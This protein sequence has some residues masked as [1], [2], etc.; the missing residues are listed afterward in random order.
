MDF[1]SLQLDTVMNIKELI[2]LSTF[3]YLGQYV[4][5][6]KNYNQDS[7]IL[8]ILFNSNND[9][10]HDVNIFYNTIIEL[11]KNDEYT[12]FNY[13]T[14]IKNAEPSIPQF[15]KDLFT[16]KGL[17]PNSTLTSK[18]DICKFLR[19]NK[20]DNDPNLHSSN[21]KKLEDS[22]SSLLKLYYQKEISQVINDI[23]SNTCKDVD[24]EQFLNDF[25]VLKGGYKLTK[26]KGGKPI[27]KSKKNC[28]DLIKDINNFIKKYMKGDE[29]DKFKCLKILI[30]RK[31]Y[32]DLLIKLFG[33]I[34]NKEK[35]IEL[36]ALLD[37]VNEQ[38]YQI[39]KGIN[40]LFITDDPKINL[41]KLG[42]YIYKSINEENYDKHDNYEDKDDSDENDSHEID[43][44]EI[45]SHQVDS[46]EDYSSED[47]E[48][49]LGLQ[50]IK[51]DS[52]ECWINSLLQA[53]KGCKSLLEKFYRI[54]DNCREPL[55]NFLKSFYDVLDL[56][57]SKTTSPLNI[58]FFNKQVWESSNIKGQFTSHSMGDST[59]LLEHIIQ[60]LELKNCISNI[61]DFYNVK[62]EY[63]GLPIL[64]IVAYSGDDL[65]K[66]LNKQVSHNYLKQ[67][68]PFLILRTK[69]ND[70]QQEF[71]PVKTIL[72]KDGNI[73]VN[74]QMFTLSSVI[75]NIRNVHYLTITKEGYFSDT[76]RKI[77]S[78]PMNKFINENEYGTTYGKFYGNLYFFEKVKKHS[79][80]ESPES[81]ESNQQF[82]TP[83][84]LDPTIMDQTIMELYYNWDTKIENEDFNVNL[85]KIIEAVLIN[86][87]NTKFI[88]DRKDNI[89]ASKK[90]I[91]EYL[92]LPL[93]PRT[94]T[95]L[96]L[97]EEEK[98]EFT[99]LNFNKQYN[100]V[101]LTE[102]LINVK[103][104]D[105]KI[106]KLYFSSEIMTAFNDL[107]RIRNTND[108]LLA[109]NISLKYFNEHHSFKEDN[110]DEYLQIEQVNKK[111]IELSKS[112]AKDEKTFSNI[113]KT[114]P[115]KF[116]PILHE[117]LD[118]DNKLNKE[119]KDILDSLK[120]P[121]LTRYNFLV[122]GKLLNNKYFDKY[123]KYKNK[124]LELCKLNSQKIGRY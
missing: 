36:N 102:F 103:L 84:V 117:F 4:C 31:K 54:K 66:V 90:W 25:N 62:S 96:T 109:N 70:R 72:P 15:I 61:S 82:D 51:N 38:I 78:G 95:T 121:T 114:I 29:V 85:N 81:P 106:K 68:A 75:L 73:K 118:G 112:F 45:D 74:G 64:Q 76:S 39:F 8:N 80:G 9:N 97:A 107:E 98:E 32:I 18:I 86:K 116:R 26:F 71:T 6:G 105:P 108:S 100:K 2:L 119:G 47:D 89:V 69:L 20:I 5:W 11:V 65:Q 91:I 58:S 59:D 104:K 79:L 52:L 24:L 3:K 55:T 22:L 50:G 40:Q 67:D 101:D 42:K 1:N 30:N 57:T 35:I 14:F 37:K 56:I 63:S 34:E 28:D 33:F 124:Y 53:I 115:S 93:P 113:E 77:G 49:K 99:H 94:N 21:K 44:H 111:L 7:Q 13:S 123:L 19:Q 23:L 48:T 17:F 16:S 10:S 120:E 92:L 87:E 88:W 12:K 46:H 122:G 60:K 41:N 83:Q 110:M 27:K 43:S